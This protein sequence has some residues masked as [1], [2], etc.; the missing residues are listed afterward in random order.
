M[1]SCRMG[2]YWAGPWDKGENECITTPIVVDEVV[3]DDDKDVVEDLVDSNWR[4]LHKDGSECVENLDYAIEEE[5]IP[6]VVDW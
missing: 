4:V 2:S 5:F 6:W 1:Y 3:G